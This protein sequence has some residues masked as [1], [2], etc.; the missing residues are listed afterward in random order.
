MSLT[1]WGER[2]CPHNPSTWCPLS[3]AMNAPGRPSCDDGKLD[4]GGCAVD[5]GG[6]Y[7]QLLGE[8]M[9]VDARLVAECQWY[10]ALWERQ[11]QRDR[12]LKLNGIH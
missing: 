5:R 4:Q 12:N 1:V 11:A 10:A 2:A 8:L 6:D 3:V 9:A 7:H